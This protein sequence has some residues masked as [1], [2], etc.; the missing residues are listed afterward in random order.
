MIF[1]YCK[2]LRLFFMRRNNF[3]FATLPKR[4]TS[5]RR[6]FTVDAC[7]GFGRL[8]FIL[9]VISDAVR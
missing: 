7:T 3:L 8:W 4:S 6:R 9:K 2:R 5:L 1:A